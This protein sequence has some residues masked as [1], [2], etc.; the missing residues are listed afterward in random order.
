MV[1]YTKFAVNWINPDQTIIVVGYKKE[2]VKKQI[3]CDGCV[4]VE[5]DQQLGTGHAVSLTKEHFKDFDGYVLIINGDTPLIRGET[6]HN[7]GE[8][9]KA[10]VRYEGVNLNTLRK[11]YRNKS[12]AGV[13][14]T[15]RVPNPTGYGRVIKDTSGRIIKIVEE[16][17]ATPQEKE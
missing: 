12:V 4:F 7:A 14:V 2:E 15:A 3:N 11:G 9:L 13:A 6:L 10:L 5:Q 16:K 17:D 1:W 8:Y